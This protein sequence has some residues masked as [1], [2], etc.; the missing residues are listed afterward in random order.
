L[1]EDKEWLL[2]PLLQAAEAGELQNGLH[3]SANQGAEHHDWDGNPSGYEGYLPENWFFLAAAML[4][5][6]GLKFLPDVK[7]RM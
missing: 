5:Q 3:V 7:N 6:T 1:Y 4:S 2:E